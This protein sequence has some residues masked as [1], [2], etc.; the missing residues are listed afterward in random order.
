MY[1]FLDFILYGLGSNN[2]LFF[3]FERAFLNKK[4]RTF[5]PNAIQMQYSYRTFTYYLQE[6]SV[7]LKIFQD[8][9]VAG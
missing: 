7:N 1:N 4:Y 2:F 5:K 8:L 3:F 6:R 9:Q